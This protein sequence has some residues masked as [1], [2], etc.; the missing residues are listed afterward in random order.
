MRWAG[1]FQRDGPFVGPVLAGS[2]AVVNAVRCH[3]SKETVRAAY[4][5]SNQSSVNR[6]PADNQQKGLFITIAG[7]PSWISLGGPPPST[8]MRPVSFN[9]TLRSRP[10]AASTTLCPEKWLGSWT[11]RT[12]WTMVDVTFLPVMPCARAQCNIKH[13]PAGITKP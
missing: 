8:M 9:K 13:N 11:G 7:D 10:M 3:G 4:G 12:E 1:P 6:Y 5:L 2:P